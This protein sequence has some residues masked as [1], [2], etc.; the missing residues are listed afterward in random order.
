LALG[1]FGTAALFGA[2]AS[3]GGDDT[4]GPTPDAGNDVVVIDNYVPPSPC[5]DAGAPA[6]TCTARQC[7]QQ[8][9]EPSVCVANQCV[10]LKTTECQDVFG[11]ADNDDAVLVGSLLSTHGSDSV[12][13]NV[14][15]HSTALAV[16]EINNTA[17][18]VYTADGCGRRPLVYI[19]CD[20]SNALVNP[21]AGAEAGAYDRVAAAKHLANELQVAAIVGP[22]NSGNTL[23]V[24]FNVTGPAKTMLMP[25]TSSAAEIS[26]SKLDGGTQDGVRLV[27]RMVPDD[28]LQGK[29]L[30]RLY[31]SVVAELAK[32]GKTTLKVAIIA[33]M[34]AYGQGNLAFMQSNLTL[35]G[36]PY[37]DA[38]NAAYHIERS[39]DVTKPVP[40]TVWQDV[41]AF[42]PDIIFHFGLG[43]FSVGVI[44]PYEDAN[45]GDAGITV[46]AGPDGG[47]GGTIATGNG[48]I[49]L[50]TASGQRGD[51]LTVLKTRPQV[52]TRIRG[53]TNLVITPLAQDFF[54]FRYK[55]AYPNDTPSLLGGM[56]NCYDAVY[57][58][59]FGATESQTK[60]GA[61]VKSI[62]VGRGFTKIVTGTSQ[63]DV[64]PAKVKDGLE[65]ARQGQAFHI[66]GA[67][68]PL[69]FDP[70]TGQTPGDF[71]VWCVRK[72]P[73]T[74]N[75]VFEN[76]TGQSWSYKTDTLGGTFTCPP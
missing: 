58:I 18:G 37:M 17:G 44:A 76:V 64:G 68:G 31:E 11:P 25:P 66:N 26:G 14:R 72:D 69:E 39:Y 6:R 8:A 27:W 62:D 73:N 5:A 54:N 20:D 3:C 60:L 71:P 52:W 50:T 53:V 70:A 23:Q 51:L 47:D 30:K 4:A 32:A 28:D 42:Q 13:G 48:P 9:G 16:N 35:N 67:S 61:A 57:M 12:A 56:A 7:T 49:W 34:D 59:A 40:A 10:K 1:L 15:V 74:G 65:Q 46:D 45:A 29:A 2:L 75:P 63:I 43:E 36:K 38:A 41:L 55:V 24:F 19:S 21:D 22:Q 33:R